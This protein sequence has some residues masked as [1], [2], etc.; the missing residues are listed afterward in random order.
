VGTILVD[1][2]TIDLSYNDATPSI[3]ADVKANSI[4]A[5]H[6]SNTINVS[7]FINDSDYATEAYVDSKIPA[8]YSK[9]VYV[10]N[11]NPNS[12][13]IFDL[14][15]PPLVNDDLLK[16]DVNN[17]YIGTDVSTWVYNGTIYVTKTVTSTTSNF[18]LSGTT[19]D[20]G[21]TKT[22][23][24]K[25]TGRVGGANAIDSNDFVTKQQLDTK[26]PLITAGTTSQYRR[27]D[28][29]WQ[30]LDKT[31][32]GL[33]N[34]DNTS[35]LNKPIS[36]AT[37]TALNLK[38][39]KSEK[40]TANGYAGLD[41][42]SKIFSNQLPAIAIT[43]TFVVASQ[44][45]M[46]A[47]TTAEVGDIAVR[48]DI[49]KTFILK[50]S[51]Y[52]TLADWQ[53]LLTPTS[54]VTSVFGRAGAV[55]ANSGDYTTSLVPEA[56]N[57]YYTEARVNANTNVAANTA[58][59]HNAVTLGTANGLSLATQA[60]SLGLSSTGATGALSSTDWNTFNS[61][62]S[63]LVSGTNIKTVGGQSLLG[64]GNLVISGGGSSYTHEQLTESTT[65][66]IP[67]VLGNKYPDVSVWN[68]SNEIIIP[69]TVNSVD[70]NNTNIV[71]STPVKGYATLSGNTFTP[72]TPSTVDPDA[73][74]FI[75]A[76]GTLNTTNQNAIKQLVTDLKGYGLWSK[77]IAFYPKAGST[78]AEHKWNLKDPR[79]LDAAYRQIYNGSI[80]HSSSGVAYNSTN[81]FA[82][83]KLN[84]ST[85]GLTGN[86]AFGLYVTVAPT[87]N[88]D[89]Y[90]IGA[91]SG[92]N[93]FV[94]IQKP[95]P[96]SIGPHAYGVN[97]IVTISTNKGFM[98]VSVIGTDRAIFH[99]NIV[100]E[101][102]SI[103]GSGVPNA[104]IYEGAL[105]SS[106]R[107][108]SMAFT[109]GTSF[110]G[111]GLNNTEMKNLRTCI[112]TFESA[113]GRN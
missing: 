34:V 4:D 85:L 104:D 19:T 79:D 75:T 22:A 7:E 27:G 68:S 113:L 72:T 16:L 30:T 55:V 100:K 49:N 63:A 5:T 106:G 8:D 76:V 23:N 84:M 25:R 53:E 86:F 61:K 97:T 1:T 29:T 64:S 10:N 56:T 32:V 77:L 107:Y 83:T 21:N 57:L 39:N 60:L 33:S 109:S 26:E 111:F 51:S 90:L 2:T 47:L 20:A 12:A 3:S 98:G 38:E 17:L 95:T 69:K 81:T 54:A 108:G 59:R 42:N 105:N 13:T 101:F 9:V 103:N 67:H 78:A 71:F 45:A 43:D 82:D 28:K 44:S 88:G 96:T 80:V 58:A 52:S 93:N 41:S 89:I 94:A 92:V 87:A 62:Q 91:Y 36:T 15:N 50:G 46:L 66:P 18:F 112:L 31:A 40:N 70:L 14:E 6:L 102:T 35:D 99:E 65:W 24:I 48:T 11:V 37:Q 110:I 73:T 74:A